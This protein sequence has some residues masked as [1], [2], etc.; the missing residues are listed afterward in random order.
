MGD[1]TAVQFGAMQTGEA[2]FASTYQA[3]QNTLTTLEGQLQ[4]SLA[5]W[6]G[7]AQQAYHVAKAKWDAAAADM[8][9]V[10][11]Q[12]GQVVGVANENYMQAES[13]NTSMWA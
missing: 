9:T 3:L 1:Y 2:D 4:S 11:S 8:A 6:T 10:V 7:G 12:L 13:V 5:E